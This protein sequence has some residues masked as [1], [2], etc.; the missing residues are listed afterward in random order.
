MCSQTCHLR[1]IAIRLYHVASDFFPIFRSSCGEEGRHTS[2]TTWTPARQCP[3]RILALA[4]ARQT[5]TW[6]LILQQ[7]IARVTSRKPA[8]LHAALLHENPQV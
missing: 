5:S 1:H 2:K 3:V 6:L 4:H 7:L 8:L